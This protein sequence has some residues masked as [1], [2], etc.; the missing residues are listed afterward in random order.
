MFHSIN[1]SH[2]SQHSSLQQTDHVTEKKDKDVVSWWFVVGFSVVVLK[3]LYSFEFCMVLCPLRIKQTHTQIL[4]W[5]KFWK[6][7]LVESLFVN[8]II[9]ECRLCPVKCARIIKLDR[10]AFFYMKKFP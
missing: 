4:I 6:F 10:K 2:N 8:C 3:I 5:R 1:H 9:N 7:L